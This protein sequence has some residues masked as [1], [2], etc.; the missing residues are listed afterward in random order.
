VIVEDQQGKAAEGYYQGM[1]TKSILSLVVKA[2]VGYSTA[3]DAP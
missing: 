2:V 1:F 3:A